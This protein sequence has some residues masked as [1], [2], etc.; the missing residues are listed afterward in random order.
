[1]IHL[2]T[3]RAPVI[4]SVFCGS[5]YYEVTSGECSKI[6]KG[7]FLVVSFVSGGIATEFV[8]N[9]LSDIVPGEASAEQPL[10]TVAQMYY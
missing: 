9:V 5:L 10:A 6:K 7:V 1:M 3:L 4:L 2:V 8:A